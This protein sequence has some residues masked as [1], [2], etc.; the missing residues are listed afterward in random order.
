MAIYKIS[1][2][3]IYKYIQNNEK[4]LANDQIAFNQKKKKE[5]KMPLKVI[6]NDF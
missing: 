6:L 5:I 2:S 4:H 1:Q 3:I